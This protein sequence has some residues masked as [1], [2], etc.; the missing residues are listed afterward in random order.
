MNYDSPLEDFLSIPYRYVGSQVQLALRKAFIL[1]K[2]FP[3]HCA[4]RVQLQEYLVFNEK[5]GV[6]GKLKWF[7]A[8]Q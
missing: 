6:V 1:Y 7:M 4:H 5:A 2:C 8:L 3:K